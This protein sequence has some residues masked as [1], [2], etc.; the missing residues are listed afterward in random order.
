VPHSNTGSPP[1]LRPLY[2]SPRHPIPTF[3]ILPSGFLPFS[4][5]GPC[6]S[7]PGQYRVIKRLFK[8]KFQCAAPTRLA[9]IFALIRRRI[10]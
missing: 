9:G 7:Q 4:R 10:A 1:K 5:V 8:P 2:L 3:R 6:G